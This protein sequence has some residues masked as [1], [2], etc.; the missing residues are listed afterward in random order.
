MSLVN[1]MLRDLDERRRDT[2]GPATK[3]KLTPAPDG[4]KPRRKF[5]IPVVLVALVLAAGGAGYVWLQINAGE[6]AT[7]Q[8]DIA[9]APGLTS[10]PSVPLESPPSEPVAQNTLNTSPVPAP[11][12]ASTT[13]AATIVAAP[14]VIDPAPAVIEPSLA[15]ATPGNRPSAGEPLIDQV[16]SQPTSEIGSASALAPPPVALPTEAELPMTESQQ[17]SL[18]TSL[19]T[20]LDAEQETAQVATAESGQVADLAQTV[21]LA[22]NPALAESVKAASALSPDEKDT[23]AVQDALRLLANNQTQEAFS[24]LEQQLQENPGAHQTRETYAKLLLNQGDNLLAQDLIETGLQLAPNHS[25]FKKVKARLMIA[26]GD[27]EDAVALLESRAPSVASDLE[28]HEILASLQLA[29]KDY[30]G[31]ALSYTGLVQQDQTQGKWWYGFA[32]AQDAMGNESAARQAYSRAIEQPNLSTSL[33][34][35]SQDRLSRLGQ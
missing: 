21:S 17:P 24:R 26:S 16:A 5:V 18:S 2:E 19:P 11:D 4:R 3:V 34:R 25:G 7:R 33:R 13:P 1:D 8:L 9:I 28:Y 29:S 23:L 35:R 30:R 15:D 10:T 22:P 14:A 6:G 20:S 31:A 27:I 32:A 12:S